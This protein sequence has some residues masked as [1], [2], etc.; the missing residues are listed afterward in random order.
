[1]ADVNAG[2]ITGKLVVDTSDL[3]RL[4]NESARTA[5][6]LKQ[7]LGQTR[8]SPI[9]PDA[10]NNIR[11]AN[12][13]AVKLA[14]SARQVY[15][16]LKSSPLEFF[17]GLAQGA[18]SAAGEFINLRRAGTESLDKVGE[19]A[20]GAHNSMRPLSS[21]IGLVAGELGALGP[22]GNV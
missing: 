20:K 19:S 12:T 14:G 13:E 22:V 16:A 2:T 15:D 3:D 7:D 18:R 6:T 17:K 8:V 1:M 4:R 9:S 21:A 11:A 5:Q 10:V